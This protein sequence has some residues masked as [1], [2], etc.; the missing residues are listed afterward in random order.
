MVAKNPK[1]YE[2]DVLKKI[3][4]MEADYMKAIKEEEADYIALVKENPEKAAT[5]STKD[6]TSRAKEA[7]KA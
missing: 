7:F 2:A 6:A 1:K 4:A 3:Q 5:E